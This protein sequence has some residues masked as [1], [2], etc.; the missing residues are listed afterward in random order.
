MEIS[1]L[2]LLIFRDKRETASQTEYILSDVKSGTL[3]RHPG[4]IGGQPVTIQKCQ[5]RQI[6]HWTLLSIYHR[7]L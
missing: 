5:V 6:V 7:F 3:C 1:L 2:L 4:T